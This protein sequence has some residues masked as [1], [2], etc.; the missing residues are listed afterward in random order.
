MV[1]KH[2]LGASGA[3]IRSRLK[4]SAAA[5]EKTKTAT[6]VTALGCTRRG[7]RERLLRSMLPRK[8]LQILHRTR[9]ATHIQFER[10]GASRA[11]QTRTITET[12]LC[13]DYAII[14][15]LNP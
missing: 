12:S 6:G 14:E 2:P 13:P 8:A 9:V 1:A 3:R 5:G 7:C 15:A 4:L 11:P 10:M